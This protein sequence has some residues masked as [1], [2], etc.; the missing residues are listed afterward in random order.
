[1]EVR[2]QKEEKNYSLL[3]MTAKLATQKPFILT[4]KNVMI[5]NL[6]WDIRSLERGECQNYPLLHHQYTTYSNFNV[7]V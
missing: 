4:Y 1:L 6:G 5:E 3:K 2:N 7:L